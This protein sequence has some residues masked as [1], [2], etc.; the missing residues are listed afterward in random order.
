MGRVTKENVEDV[1]T[2]QAPDASQVDKFARVRTALVA[3]A[4]VILDEVPDCADKTTALRKLREARM[5]ANAAIA[6]KGLI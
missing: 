5:D 6:L 4:K 3:A 1:F 2:Y